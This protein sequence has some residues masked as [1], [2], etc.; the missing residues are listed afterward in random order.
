MFFYTATC[1]LKDAIKNEKVKLV[2]DGAKQSYVQDEQVMI[3][4]DFG[5]QM[6]DGSNSVIV[7]ICLSDQ[8]WSGVDPNCSRSKWCIVTHAAD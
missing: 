7:R 6:G 3:E 1:K 2:N 8:T 4:C 5:Y